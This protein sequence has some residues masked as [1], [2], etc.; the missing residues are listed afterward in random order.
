MGLLGALAGLLGFEAEAIIEQIK[1][2]AVAFSVIG[3]FAVIAVVFLLI[4]ADIGLTAW[5]GPLWAA[6]AIAL[7]AIVIA[8]VIFIALRVQMAARQRRRAE[9]RRQTE[10]TA[11]A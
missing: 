1:E 9:Q 3:L 10:S 8:L 7:A 4:A 11:M 2:Q 6:I 5:I